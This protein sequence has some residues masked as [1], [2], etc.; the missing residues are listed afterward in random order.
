MSREY[1]TVA[2]VRCSVNG[3]RRHETVAGD[4]RSGTIEKPVGWIELRVDGSAGRAEVQ[5]L[6]PDHVKKFYDFLC[7]E[8]A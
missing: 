8:K 3:C 6:C 5:D 2:D 1:R 7:G 4:A